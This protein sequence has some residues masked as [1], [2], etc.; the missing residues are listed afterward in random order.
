MSEQLVRDQFE[1]LSMIPEEKV[2]SSLDDLSRPPTMSD[3]ELIAVLERGRLVSRLRAAQ[4]L[5]S[6]VVAYATDTITESF[7]SSTYLS[8]VVSN[9]DALEAELMQFDVVSTAESSSSEESV[10]DDTVESLDAPN[11]QQVSGD[12]LKRRESAVCAQT[13]P[14]IFFPEKGGSTKQ[15]KKVCEQSCDMKDECLS[16]ALENHER[17]GIWGG[18]SERERRT[19]SKK[20]IA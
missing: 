5:S 15:A 6:I 19:L 4:R 2:Q 9:V 20:S 13:D 18:L 17:F 12:F 8:Q 10:D 7:I 14:E 1:H 11:I 3:A 16:Y